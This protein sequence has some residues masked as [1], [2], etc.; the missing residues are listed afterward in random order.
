MESQID[1]YQQCVKTLL[2]E[3]QSLQTP[4]SEV[5]LLF[6]DERMRYMVMQVGWSKQKRIHVCMVHIDIVHEVIMIQCNNTEDPVAAELVKMGISKERIGLG[7]VP[8]EARQHTEYC[9]R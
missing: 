4:H 8:P 1:F 2:A 9:C 3:Y 7:F 5:E 6:D